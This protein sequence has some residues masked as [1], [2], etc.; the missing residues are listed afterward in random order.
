MTDAENLGIFIK[1]LLVAFSIS[2]AFM[3]SVHTGTIVNNTIRKRSP[4]L[5]FSGKSC[6]HTYTAVNTACVAGGIHRIFLL[7]STGA[8]IVFVQAVAAS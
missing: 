3:V 7:Q 1:A 8:V 5:I 6:S 2:Y 4:E